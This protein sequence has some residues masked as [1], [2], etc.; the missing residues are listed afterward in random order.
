MKLITPSEVIDFAFARRETINSDDISPT[1]IDIATEQ[2]IS[3]RIG[4]EFMEKLCEGQ[5]DDFTQLY[6]KPALA[7]YTRYL[8]MD[9]LQII[10]QPD[11]IIDYSG[12]SIGDTPSNTEIHRYQIKSLADANTL[13]SKAIRHLETNED[14]YGRFIGSPKHYF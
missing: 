11:G 4:S 12:N 2:Y 10:I 13:L 6:I 7:Y 3:P 9:N 8:L 14:I 1:T 5:F